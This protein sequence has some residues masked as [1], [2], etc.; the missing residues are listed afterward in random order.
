MQSPFVTISQ[1]L[2]TRQDET[3]RGEMTE[4]AKR[5]FFYLEMPEDCRSLVK[6]LKDFAEWWFKSGTKNLN[7]FDG[8]DLI[9]GE[10]AYFDQGDWALFLPEKVL[11]LTQKISSISIEILKTIYSWAGFSERDY[12]KISGGATLGKGKAVLNLTHY[13]KEI[14]QK[15]L[16]E[17]RDFGQITLLL[18]DKIGLQVL[19]QDEWVDVDPMDNYFVIIFGQTLEVLINNKSQLIA[20]NHRVAQVFEDRI[21]M[22]LFTH[23]HGE[24]PIYQR[25]NKE[26]LVYRT[27]SYEF[28]MECLA[29]TE[30]FK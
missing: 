11:D 15:G 6:E 21:S 16:G 23:N 7:E 19:F 17:H 14:N 2:W 12:E 13:R 9:Q 1:G 29:N 27:T 20:A 26:L 25:I 18:I 30:A 10:K 22:A 5:G 24:T 28:L 3:L 4:A 8:G